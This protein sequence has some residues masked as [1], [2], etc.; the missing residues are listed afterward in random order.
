MV[1]AMSAETLG[2]YR[3][4]TRLITENRSCAL[5][6]SCESRRTR[7]FSLKSNCSTVIL[8]V[9]VAELL[10]LCSVE[11][12]LSSI[13]AI[14]LTITRSFFFHLLCTWSSFWSWPRDWRRAGTHAMET[15]HWRSTVNFNLDSLVP[16]DISCDYISCNRRCGEQKLSKKHSLFTI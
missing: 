6:S 11:A 2:N 4:S 8:N 12:P 14:P 10:V 5:N 13:I 3:N 16:W 1:A 7:D 9:A 15:K